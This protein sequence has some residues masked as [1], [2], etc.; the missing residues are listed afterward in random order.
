M[1]M[2]AVLHE[3]L[4]MVILPMLLPLI[5]LIK[6]DFRDI[7]NLA[8][9]LSVIHFSQKFYGM[10]LLQL[11]FKHSE[12]SKCSNKCYH[13]KHAKGDYKT[14]TTIWFLMLGNDSLYFAI[15]PLTPSATRTI[16][17]GS[18]KDSHVLGKKGKLLFTIT[19]HLS[20][21]TRHYSLVLFTIT[22]HSEILPI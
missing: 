12:C 13:F 17:L 14:K 19:I 4:L 20:L 15:I 6:I 22:V 2:I 21:F 18:P 8:E 3:V 7:P 16:I 11:C 10:L 9:H 1:I 5:R